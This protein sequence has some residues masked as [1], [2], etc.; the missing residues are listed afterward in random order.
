MIA[1][2]ALAADPPRPYP[3]DAQTGRAIG[4]NEVDAKELKKRLDAGEQVLLIEVRDASFY[5]QETLPGAIHIPFAQLPE[6]LKD[7]PKDRT[8]VFTCGTGRTSSQAAKLAE[9]QGYKTA[10]F[11]PIRSWKE[12]G[13]TMEPG[14]KP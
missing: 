9:E 14:K 8:L 13:Y 3:T 12:Q 4:A 11:C 1:L 2:P 7:I 10:S 5:E 6:A